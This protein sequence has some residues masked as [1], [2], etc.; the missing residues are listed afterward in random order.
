MY[1]PKSQITPNLHTNGNEYT[2]K[3][4]G[5][6]YIGYYWKSSSGKFFTGRTPQDMPIQELVQAKYQESPSL[7]S[8]PNLEI[9]LINNIDPIIHSRF[10]DAFEI[11]KYTSLTKI[12]PNKKTPVPIYS[13]TLPTS[14]DYQIGQFVRFFCKKTNEIT[15]LEISK[16]TYNKLINKN[17]NI[18]YQ[19]YQ[20]F[21]INWQLTG[22]K[23]QVYKVNKNIVELAMKQY[24][25]PQF[26]LYLKED[27][28]KYYQ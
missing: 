16:E 28:T 26:N 6:N 20:P 23:T 22:D 10:Y 18:F 8:P 3:S 21:N 5:E 7:T 1:F 4:T 2:I 27:Y 15:Y 17:P 13:L 19:L 9:A 24:K 25:L 12:D 11:E 14:Q